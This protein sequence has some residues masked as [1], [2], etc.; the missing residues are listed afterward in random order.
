MFFWG[1]VREQYEKASAEAEQRFRDRLKAMMGDDS[2]ENTKRLWEAFDQLNDAPDPRERRNLH[3]VAPEKEK[4]EQAG[5][6]KKLYRTLC[7]RHHPDKTGVYNEKLWLE[8]QDAYEK[9]SVKKLRE[10]LKRPVAKADDSSFGLSCEEIQAMIDAL[11]KEF[12]PV[13]A[14]LRSAKKSPAWDFLKWDERK[15]EERR[16]DLSRQADE[17]L[18][19]LQ[20][21]RE[22]RKAKVAGFFKP[23]QRFKKVQIIVS[24]DVGKKASYTIR[25]IYGKHEKTLPFRRGV[26]Q[27][28]SVFAERCAVTGS[29]R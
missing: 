3:Q 4:P 28:D 9:G 11:E 26:R 24:R 17:S 6:I 19:R 29:V 10:L 14:D 8:I 16:E 12:K 13:R 1:I 22:Q 21:Q 2:S 20:Q 27:A 18:A 5:E 7:L 25:L 23:N 15:R